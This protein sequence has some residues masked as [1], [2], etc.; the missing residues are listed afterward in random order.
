MPGESH[1]N[2]P[3]FPLSQVLF[4]AMPLALH[5]FEDRYKEMLRDL[6]HVNNRF[7]VALIHEGVEAGGEADPY[8]IGCIAK[9]TQL[10]PL[11]GGTFFARALGQ[12]RVRIE[13]L[14]RLTKPYLLGSVSPLPEDPTPPDPALLNRVSR[15][16]AEYARL[17]VSLS[18]ETLEGVDLPTDPLTLSSLVASMLQ[19]PPEKKQVLLEL[20]GSAARLQSEAAILRVELPLLRALAGGSRPPEGRMN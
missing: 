20:P 7:V 4:P 18:G 1:P 3:V 12:E 14:D 10:Q 13:S 19:V 11:P 16:F 2:L 15:S 8:S 5:I 17:L 6:P 9:A